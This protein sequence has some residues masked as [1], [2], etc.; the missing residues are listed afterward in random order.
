[1]NSTSNGQTEKKHVQNNKNPISSISVISDSPIS[2]GALKAD[3]VSLSSGQKNTNTS[4]SVAIQKALN[5][6]KEPEPRSSPP[7]PKS[8]NLSIPL[9]RSP[10]R[11]SLKSKSNVQEQNNN[12]KS[13]NGQSLPTSP[14]H[15]KILIDEEQKLNDSRIIKSM[16]LGQNATPVALLGLDKVDADRQEGLN[17]SL[18]INLSNISNK[19]GELQIPTIQMTGII[20]YKCKYMSDR[21]KHI[22][23]KCKIKNQIGSGSKNNTWKQSYLI[24]KSDRMLYFYAKE[25][26]KTPEKRSY[27]HSLIG[28][29]GV[30]WLGWVYFLKNY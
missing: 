26:G 10:L 15:K 4:R 3:M 20:T 14:V 29:K 1:M 21:R 12:N 19:T 27:G 30:R 28:M 17:S 11:S 16:K 5:N 7:K 18:P 24:L 25:V 6:I 22:I 23:Q 9:I 2:E 13:S 8:L